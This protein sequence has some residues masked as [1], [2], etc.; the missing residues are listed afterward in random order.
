M[1]YASIRDMDISNGIGIRVSLFVQG[2]DL[3]CKN[4]FNPET[5]D[6]DS[7][8]QWTDASSRK[9]LE[10][11]DKPYIEGL[12][13]LGG[14]PLHSCNIKDMIDICIQF[15]QRFPN[16]DIW[17]W[18]G[19]HFDMISDNSDI[20]DLAD[21]IID[22]PYIHEQRDLSLKWRGSKNQHI[23]HKVDGEWICEE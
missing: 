17:I 3:H 4:C 10:L 14:E 13:I 22:G 19:Y 12:S 20:L 2:C 8:L 15:K 5:W 1:R 16:K 9:L 21:Y 23:W 7:G 18:T 6:W 11:C